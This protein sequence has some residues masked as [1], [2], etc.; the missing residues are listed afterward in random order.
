[1][2]GRSLCCLGDF[3]FIFLICF[4]ITISDDANVLCAKF[5]LIVHL[6]VSMSGDTTLKVLRRKKLKQPWK[7]VT[8]ADFLIHVL[9]PLF[10]DRWKV[11]HKDF[12]SSEKQEKPQRYE[13]THLSI[14]KLR[15]CQMSSGKVKCIYKSKPKLFT[16]H[17]LCCIPWVVKVLWVITY[18][19]MTTWKIN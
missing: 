8:D 3:C 16:V 17:L 18:C 1:M 4:F 11:I 12:P 10:L 19:H 15:V 5:L 9:S 14:F 7:A 6:L 2:E 13:L